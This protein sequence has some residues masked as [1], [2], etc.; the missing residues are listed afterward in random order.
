MRD[1][2][3]LWTQVARVSGNPKIQ[4]YGNR[5]KEIRHR[6][7]YDFECPN[8]KSDLQYAMLNTY[9]ILKMIDDL[10]RTPDPVVPGSGL[11]S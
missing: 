10:D 7:D 5:V 1:H 9:E 6:A 2:E 11:K 4:S 8:L 3:R